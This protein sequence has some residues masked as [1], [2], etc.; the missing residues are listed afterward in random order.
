MNEKFL[1]TA[2]EL[3]PRLVYGRKTVKNKNAVPLGEGQSVTFDFGNHY[4]GYVTLY[5]SQSGSHQDAPAL[6]KVR[7]GET[8]RDIEED[9]SDYRSW[10]SR[11]WLQE[12]LLHADVLPCRLALPR[13]YAFRYVKVE[14]VAVSSKY[15]LIVNSAAVRHVTSAPE[16][17]PLCGK[18]E[19][20][21]TIDKIAVRTLS[22]CMQDVFEDGPKR[23]RR[24]WLGDLRLQALANYCTFAHNDLVKRCLYLFAATADE[25][26]RISACVF[27]EPKVAA[28]D[29]YMFD[30]SLLFINTLEEY[31][32]ATG[33]RTAAEELL[34]VALRQLSLA[35]GDMKDFVVQNSDR[36]GWCFL[37]WT[38]ELH[39]QAGAQAVYI[40]AAKAA[41]RLCAA[42]G[43][44][45]SDILTRIQRAEQ[46]AIAAFYDEA[47]GLFVSGEAR[48]ISYAA[49]V[50][51]VLAEVFPARQNAE[52]LTRLKNCAQAVKPVTPYLYHYY[53]Q[54]L[55][56]S[57]LER[58]AEEVM[59]AYWGAMA[60]D[61]ADTFYELFD[62]S[63]PSASPYGSR[64]ANS[65]CHAWSC[66]PSYFLRKY[67]TK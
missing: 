44:D 67:F 65:Y 60:D 32:S 3:K 18:D 17:L 53:V 47:S 62:P 19:K 59:L 55:I 29:T 12:E 10:I 11:G 15:S 49:N 42:L 24:L 22:E 21:Q 41:A 63:D 51:F 35:E 27:T 30:Y 6:I 61:G 26:G 50:W 25:E 14:V 45:A 64:A 4:V 48:Q 36:L 13:R 38:L 33:D 31:Y 57:G 34:P 58:E 46:A 40:C 8:P 5:L 56:N 39:K 9:T 43:K 54:A 37:D 23:D 2:E 28:D 7:F 66:T 20:S 1:R 52:L 16:S